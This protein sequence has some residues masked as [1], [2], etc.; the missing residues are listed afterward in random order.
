VQRGRRAFA[1]AVEGRADAQGHFEI[2]TFAGDSVGITAYAPDGEPYLNP[3]K[4]L[5]W[6]KGTVQQEIE[7]A[8]PRGILVR[9]TVTEKASGK[10]VH[11]ATVEFWPYLGDNREIQ[12][13]STVWTTT[14]S[15]GSF[16]VA[17]PSGH[18]HLLING[19]SPDYIPQIVGENE[20]HHGRPG[21]QPFYFHALLPLSLKTDDATKDVHITLRRGV[22]VKGY[23]VGPDDKPVRNAQMLCGGRPAPLER[24]LRPL[25]IRDGT[26]ELRGCDPEATYPVLFLTAPYQPGIN[27]IS[28]HSNKPTLMMKLHLAPFFGNAGWLGAVVQVSAKQAGSEPMRVRLTPCASVRLRLV[29]GAEQL[30][31]LI[32]L[33]PDL[34]L[35]VKPGP[36]LNEAWD[37]SVLAGEI[38]ALADS[39]VRWNPV[40]I[41][42]DMQGH[43]TL[44]GLIPGAT[45]RINNLDSTVATEFQAPTHEPEKSPE[46]TVKLH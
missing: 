11:G 4:H 39:W 21:G 29:N 19:P 45:Y 1:G 34:D 2:N 25:P 3:I 9:G 40:G 6:P 8:L 41:A 10:P 38:V 36:D 13:G 43:L 16:R 23:L 15:D 37:R 27:W 26:F 42:T 17:V 35:V 32:K 24:K 12:S 33:C 46:I 20:L 30:Q 5:E 22:S 7:I 14:G 31:P 44:T 18:G 28:V